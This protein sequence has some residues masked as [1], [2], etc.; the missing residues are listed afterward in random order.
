MDS[1][2]NANAFTGN[3]GNILIKTSGIFGI[4]FRK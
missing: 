2:I 1:D 3:G 4:Q